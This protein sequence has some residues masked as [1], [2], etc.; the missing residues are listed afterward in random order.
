MS[1]ARAGSATNSLIRAARSA[2]NRDGSA[3]SPIP[4]GRGSIGTRSPVTPSSTT[5]GMPPVAVATT[6]VWHAMASRFTIPS[7]SYTEGHTNTVACDIISITSERGTSPSIQVIR[8][9]A[10]W[11][12]LT[13]AVISRLISSVSGAPARRTTCAAGSMDAAALARWTIPFCLVIR[14]T[15]RTTG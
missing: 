1:R 10:S 2:A 12:S 8:P 14:P 13:A 7:G 4:S 11:A 3:G 6:A 15:N 9:R 5:S